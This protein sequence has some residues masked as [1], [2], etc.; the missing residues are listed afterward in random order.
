MH[1]CCNSTILMFEIFSTVMS[2]HFFRENTKRLWAKGR[3]PE[4]KLHKATSTFWYICL[5]G[6]Q[7]FDKNNVDCKGG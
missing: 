6:C 4:A 2:A 3:E 1:E 5:W 7:D